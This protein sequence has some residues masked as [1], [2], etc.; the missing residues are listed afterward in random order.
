MKNAVVKRE[1]A[2]VAVRGG[3]VDFS[4]VVA[5]C[6]G[7]DAA[8]IRW[9]IEAANA[10]GRMSLAHAIFAGW[11]LERQKVQ[12]GWGGWRDW[13]E[14]NLGFSQKTA[15]RYV[16]LYRKTIGAAR[17][18]AGIGAGQLVSAE[19]L[20]AATEAVDASTA[21]GAM[22]ELGIV[23][24]NPAHGGF[25]PGSGR[26][27]KGSAEEVEA[28]LDAAANYEPAMW[29]SA[30]GAIK[31]V[32]ELDAKKQLF[33]RLEDGHLAMA[34][35]MLGDLARKAGEALK[36]RLARRDMGLHGEAMQTGEVVKVLEGG[37]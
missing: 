35:Q 10:L 32:A 20:A 5:H 19:E 29:A 4:E 15:D 21:T 36:A 2:P 23:K 12:V 3:K 33:S 14:Q 7:D 18:P 13:C 8:L 26:R 27:P 11:L 16:E 30:E 6:Q 25:R 1:T 28:A 31:T 22:V 37:M 24:R 9:H 34:A 17:T